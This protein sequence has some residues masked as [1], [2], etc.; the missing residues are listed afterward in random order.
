[1]RRSCLPYAVLGS[2]ACPAP[3]DALAGCAR[4]GCRS[5]RPV[6]ARRHVGRAVPAGAPPTTGTKAA[7]TRCQETTCKDWGAT[8]EGRATCAAEPAAGVAAGGAEGHRSG[9]AG[10]VRG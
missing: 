1:M 2:V 9:T 7:L 6:P 4:A 3:G 10:R 5:L 8:H